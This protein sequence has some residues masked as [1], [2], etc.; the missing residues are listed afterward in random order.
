MLTSTVKLSDG[1]EELVFTRNLKRGALNNDVYNCMLCS[2]YNMA[3][4]VS[5]RT[6]IAGRKH[7]NKLKNEIIDADSFRKRIRGQKNQS[8]G[9]GVN[10]SRNDQLPSIVVHLDI[11]PGE[12]VPP[13]LEDEVKPVAEIQKTLDEYR[14][15]PTIGLEYIIEFTIGN[16]R[17][18]LYLCA[19][20]SE[21]TDMKTV[22]A[23][24]TGYKH[25]LKYLVRHRHDSCRTSC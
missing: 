8:V 7:Q 24:A 1:T 15:M 9:V 19:L 10:P 5:L 3:G 6:H 13:G 17:E 20:C 2:A 25:R 12:P 16:G 4:D 14:E 23:H 21:R 18:P 22:L 11:A